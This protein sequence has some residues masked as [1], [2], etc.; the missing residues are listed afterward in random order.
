MVTSIDS[1]FVELGKE[2]KLV[3]KNHYFYGFIK[4]RKFLSYFC[5][6]FYHYVRYLHGHKNVIQKHIEASY[7]IASHV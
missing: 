6:I 5:W 3:I 2:N 4:G 7:G 1:S